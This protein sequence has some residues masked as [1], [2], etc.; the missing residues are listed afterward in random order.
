MKDYKVKQ[1]LYHKTSS[2]DDLLSDLEHRV[3]E[4]SPKDTIVWVLSYFRSEG[5][6]TVF[7]AKSYAVAIIYAKLLEKYF[8]AEF[9]S[10]LKDEELFLGSDRF[11]VP[12]GQ[13]PQADQIYDEVFASLGPEEW[14]F[15]TSPYSQVLKTVEYF[16]LEFLS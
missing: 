7:P 13:D 14:S 1:W 4:L 15:E 12:Y 2:P 10:S 8:K 9:W 6:E 5:P 3:V 16:Y 11:F